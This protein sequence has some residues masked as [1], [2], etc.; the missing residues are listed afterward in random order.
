MSAADETWLPDT[1]WGMR[2]SFSVCGWTSKLVPAFFA[3]FAVASLLGSDLAGWVAAVIV[4][5]AIATHQARTGTSATCAM[6]PAP[7]S[8]DESVSAD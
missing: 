2:S 8:A 4:G 1:L 5:L 3:G 7:D 6:P